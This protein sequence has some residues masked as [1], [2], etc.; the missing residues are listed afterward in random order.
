MRGRTAMGPG[1]ARLKRDADGNAGLAPGRAAA[2]LRQRNLRQVRAAEAPGA[3][4]PTP[5]SSQHD[6]RQPCPAPAPTWPADSVTREPE[7]LIVTTM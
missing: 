3:G 6:T 1:V 4:V 7:C 2:G 5:G